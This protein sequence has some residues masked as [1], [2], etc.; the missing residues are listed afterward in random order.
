M[1]VED[2]VFIMKYITLLLNPKKYQVIIASDPNL[3]L[4]QWHSRSGEIDLVI[5]DFNLEASMNGRQLLEQMLGQKLQLQAILMSGDFPTPEEVKSDYSS[6]IH[7][8]GKPFSILQF[9]NLVTHCLDR[10]RNPVGLAGK[11]GQIPM[12]SPP[13]EDRL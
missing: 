13:I 7:F 11:L 12:V 5:S 9:L 3:A 4:E 1:V 6:R 8:L 10:A 2:E